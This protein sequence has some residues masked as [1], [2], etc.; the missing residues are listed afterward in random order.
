MS[1]ITVDFNNYSFQIDEPC[2]AAF[3]QTFLVMRLIHKWP[4]LF[5]IVI[6]LIHVFFVI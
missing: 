4:F 3:Q 2:E 1:L 5:R 6:Y